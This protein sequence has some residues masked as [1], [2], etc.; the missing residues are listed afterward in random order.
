MNKLLVAVVDGTKARFLT[1]D[2]SDVP[3]ERMRARLVELESLLNP[4]NEVQDQDLWSSSKT[5]RNRG[6]GG[7]AHSYDDHREHHRAEFERRFAQAIATH[8][9]NLVN[10]HTIQQLIL[11]AEPQIT[12][13]MRN[14]I[15]ASVPT[16]LQIHELSKNLC[17][18]KPHEL[19]KYLAN[20]KL[21][22]EPQRIVD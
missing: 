4:S 8:I 1:L 3:E 15:A 9:A 11:V 5:G 10:T 6:A 13:P 18:L 17:H 20:Q 21:M 22:P 14:A 16:R 12:G 7:Q 2:L 19:Q